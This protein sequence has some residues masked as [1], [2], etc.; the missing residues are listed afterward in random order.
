MIPIPRMPYGLAVGALALALTHGAA[1]VQGRH[2]GAASEAVR[3]AEAIRAC[4]QA[5]DAAR[6]QWVARVDAQTA[7]RV[8]AEQEAA[9]AIGQIRIEHMPGRIEVR[10]EVVEMP[11]YRDCA[12][13]D[14]VRDILAAALAGTPVPA[15]GAV[16]ADRSIVPGG[17]AGAEG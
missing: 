5:A 11:V 6:M 7:A 16:G 10:R 17:V 4:E 15:A 13:S 8:A 3:G 2:D 14:R 12:V 9:H 1:Y